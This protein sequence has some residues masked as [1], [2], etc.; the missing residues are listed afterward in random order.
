[1]GEFLLGLV[2]EGEEGFFFLADEHEAV[3]IITFNIS[4]QLDVRDQEIVVLVLRRLRFT[5]S[6]LVLNQSL[7]R[8]Y[9]TG[10]IKQILL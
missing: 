7:A 9:L 6:S 1:L 4:G 3:V 2:V 10:I 5:C 8:P